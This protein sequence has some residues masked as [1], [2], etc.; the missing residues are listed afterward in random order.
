MLVDPGASSGLVG[1]DT[2]KELMES[3]MIPQGC[4]GEVSWGP[5]TTTVTGISGQSEDMEET[6]PSDDT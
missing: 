3:G 2:L 5:S 1:T 6:L 4:E